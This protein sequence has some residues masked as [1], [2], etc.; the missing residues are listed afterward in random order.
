MREV[1]VKQVT[2]NHHTVYNLFRVQYHLCQLMS[3]FIS[4]RGCCHLSQGSSTMVGGNSRQVAEHHTSHT[5][6]A[7]AA[8]APG[9]S[10][11]QYDARHQ[12]QGNFMSVLMAKG[13]VK[14]DCNAHLIAA[15]ATAVSTRHGCY[16]QQ[17]H[18]AGWNGC[19]YTCMLTELCRKIM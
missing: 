13:D 6:L 16:I 4:G 17:Q 8:A 3:C 14:G 15:T 10:R 18:L 5:G 19:G 1:A 9:G 12:M 7:A 2:W 11:Q